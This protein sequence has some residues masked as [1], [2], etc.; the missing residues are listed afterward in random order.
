MLPQVLEAHCTLLD[1]QASWQLNGW[2][3]RA[4]AAGQAGRHPGS[5]AAN[6]Q[7]S[8]AA[9]QPSFLAP[10]TGSAAPVVPGPICCGFQ[11]E[12]FR[13]AVRSSLRRLRRSGVTKTPPHSQL[14]TRSLSTQIE[15]SAAICLFSV[16]VYRS[17]QGREC[18]CRA[19]HRQR[20]EGSSACSVFFCGFSQLKE[21]QQRGSSKRRAPGG[22]CP[23][24]ARRPRRGRVRARPLAAPP[25]D[26]E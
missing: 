11:A 15:M 1:R 10:Q 17:L 14:S 2:V 24:R 6:G 22:R 23:G 26:S 18:R 25:A 20:P 21:E 4:G 13:Q 16:S 8:K 3:G 5:S 12:N 9:R 19:Q 7:A